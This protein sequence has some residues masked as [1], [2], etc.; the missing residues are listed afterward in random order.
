MNVGVIGCG[1]IG[2]KRAAALSLFPEDKLIAVCDIDGERASTLA[3]DFHCESESE[4]RRLVQRKD[5]DVIINSSINEVL[6]EI[7]VGALQHKKHVLCEKP[8]GRNSAEAQRMVD[9]A[10]KNTVLLKTGFNHIFHPA[11]WKAKE[12]VDSG[13]IGSLLS[14][15]ARYGHGSRPG[16]EKEWRSSKKLCGGGELLDQGVHVIDLIRW[17]TGEIEQVYSKVETKFWNIEVEDNAFALMTCKNNV[18]AMFHVSWTNWRN[19]FS[20][21]LFGSN[22]YLA[23]NGLGGSYGPE[24]L[25]WGKRKQ[26]GGRPDIEVY[27]FSP[28]DK[29]WETEWNEFRTAIKE[30]REPLKKGIDGLRANQIVEAMYQSQ[31]LNT[32]ITLTFK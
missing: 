19:I 8:L 6:E 12:F 24:T 29:S 27:E 20:F 18:T 31:K 16:M 17:F 14:I 5:I 9:A 30:K 11:L 3:K 25:E 13:G 4:W 1:L 28:S 21:E 2:R 23:V 32:P 7:S 22:G 15:R 26:E 10:Q